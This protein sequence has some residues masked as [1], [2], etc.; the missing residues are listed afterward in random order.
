[1][2][3]KPKKNKG[4]NNILSVYKMMNNIIQNCKIDRNSIEGDDR[5]PTHTG[6][7]KVGNYCITGSAKHSIY[8]ECLDPN[9]GLTEKPPPVSMLRIDLD[10]KSTNLNEEMDLKEITKKA[11]KKIIDYLEDK[12]E[13]TSFDATACV[14]TKAPYI[15]EEKKI[16][17]FGIHIQYPCIFLKKADQIKLCNDL[18]IDGLDSASATNNW[19][20][21]G[22]QKNPTSSTYK[23][24]YMLSPIDNK[25]NTEKG[26]TNFWKCYYLDDNNRVDID[27]ELPFK[28]IFSIL[29]NGR[30]K[31]FHN[32]KIDFDKNKVERDEKKFK[33]V[34][35]DITELQKIEVVRQLLPLITKYE[36]K[37]WFLTLVACKNISED[38]LEDFVEHTKLVYKSEGDSRT[39]WENYR[40]ETYPQGIGY[41]RNLAKTDNPELYTSK[42]IEIKSTIYKTNIEE[43]LEG[44]HR[45]IAG[46]FYKVWMKENM[47]INNSKDMSV[48]IWC[49]KKKL[50]EEH[51]RE[52]L[53]PVVGRVLS[54]IYKKK[55]DKLYK[56]LEE[57]T[58]EQ[59]KNKEGELIHAKIKKV[60]KLYLNVNSA[61][62]CGHVCKFIIDFGV[63]KDFESKVIN[64]TPH[65]LPIKGGKVIDLKTLEIR[66]RTQEDFW[67]FE[68][69]VDFLG[70]DSDLSSV[71]K[72]FDS[73]CLGSKDLIDYH[74]RM[75]GYML[76][77]NITDRSIHI[78]WG[79]GKNGKSS[80]I[81]IVRKI[82]GKFQCALSED[83][84]MKKTSKGATDDLMPLM[85]ARLGI[86]PESDKEEELNSKRVKTMTGND[87]IN[88]RHLYGHSV[89]FETQCK[90][91][92]ATNFKP[93]INIQDQ[94]I[95]DRIKLVPFSATFEKT[96]ENTK[97]IQ[98]LQTNKIN[99]FFTWFCIGACEWYNGKELIPCAEMNSEMDKFVAENDVVGEFIEETYDTLTKDEYTKIQKND[100]KDYRIQKKCVFGEFCAWIQDNQYR[101]KI[102]K[103]EF[104]RLVGKKLGEPVKVQGILY[105]IC[106]KKEKDEIIENHFYP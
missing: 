47:K 82:L 70:R 105:F 1:M 27:K 94:A 64:K 46:I 7:Q 59:I 25:P 44:T 87:V 61:P 58:E 99:E 84:M 53:I 21:Y 92:W 74:K 10:Y 50:W 15:D 63:D 4:E 6:I 72:F 39:K 54:P 16:K 95:L 20:I 28:K 103:K 48:H 102:G 57:L 69:N 52:I 98:D 5:K 88:A 36:Y 34:Y 51:G 35:T 17:K 3:L 62:F 18:D 89:Q 38:L 26:E 12:V 96:A 11:N 97:Y 33:N 14:L 90:P 76:S 67:S 100:K 31:Y 106:Q 49:P 60:Q 93:I 2:T 40:C 30:Y 85:S 65:E 32:F 56:R 77:G 101:N 104:F 19:L 43:S 23:F 8:T 81:G 79:D 91:I 22:Q 9:I 55:R 83:F 80:I 78:L 45:S 13:I 68:C 75:W 24:E 37:R 73:I 66:E 29:P 71:E 41:I 86:L 42:S